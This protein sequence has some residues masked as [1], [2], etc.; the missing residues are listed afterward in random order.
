MTRFWRALHE[1]DAHG[2]SAGLVFGKERLSRLKQMALRRRVWFKT[3]TRV[4]R[5]LVELTIRVAD[6]VRSLTLSRALFSVVRKLEEAFEYR[7]LHTMEAIGLPLA[8][9]FS[10]LAQKWGN[11]MA[12]RWTENQ[13]FARFLAIMQINNT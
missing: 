12:T 5:V 7:I 8:R 10:L 1:K 6:H 3:L 11:K 13:S 4:D 2:R 9:K